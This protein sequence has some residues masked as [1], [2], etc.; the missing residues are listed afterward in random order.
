MTNAADKNHN[1]NV[2]PNISNRIGSQFLNLVSSSLQGISQLRPP[3]HDNITTSTQSIKSWHL[4]SSQSQQQVSIRS[5]TASAHFPHFMQTR[6]QCMSW[7]VLVGRKVGSDA[8]MRWQIRQTSLSPPHA[9]SRNPAK[10]GFVD[11]SA[12]Q[13]YSFLIS[14]IL[15]ICWEYFY[16]CYVHMPLC[17]VVLCSMVR[18]S[19]DIH[20][21]IPQVGG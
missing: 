7:L 11:S 20:L 15:C 13:V 18:E 21:V 8:D 12:Q 2:N 10:L 19:S 17:I 1:P 3:C 5:H 4:A 6:S 9:L 16:W 14:I